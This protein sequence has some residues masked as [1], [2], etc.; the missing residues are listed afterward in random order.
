MNEVFA[1]SC[2]I[3]GVVIEPK[4]L[5]MMPKYFGRWMMQ[6]ETNI[7]G[8]LSRICAADSYTQVAP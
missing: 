7:Y 4:R 3:A 2:L 5:D 1:M 8:W 6:T